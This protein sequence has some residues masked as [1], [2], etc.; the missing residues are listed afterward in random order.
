MR[1]RCPQKMSSGNLNDNLITIAFSIKGDV[2]LKNLKKRNAKMEEKIN[3]LIINKN[4][5]GIS[6][7]DQYETDI[8]A[9]GNKIHQLG[10]T[11]LEVRENEVSLFE[12]SIETAQKETQQ[13]GVKTVIFFSTSLFFT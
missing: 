3:S 8:S 7:K 1:V 4:S 5:G 11:E 2:L 10:L 9:L 13:K 6:L 12:D